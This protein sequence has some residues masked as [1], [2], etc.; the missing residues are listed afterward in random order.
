MVVGVDVGGK[1]KGFH[2]VALADGL[3]SAKLA[4]TS[5]SE[6]AHWCAVELPAA[7]IAVD[8]PCRWSA[9]AG[10]RAAERELRARHITCFVT[11]TRAAALSH[12][13]NYYEWM[14]RG[15]SLYQALEATHPVCEAWPSAR[16][17]FCFETFPHAI[18]WQMRGGGADARHKRVQRRRLLELNGIDV[19]ELTTMD[20]IDA[21]LCALIAHFA[22]TGQP[23]KAF[24][25]PISGLIIAPE[26]WPRE[27]R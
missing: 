22:F 17:R 18:T 21:A 26:T 15:E 9:D 25:E 8:A 20:F 16:K 3:Y 24:G 14:L 19:A 1:R 5:E 12:A 2:A 4:T 27:A 11:P 23:L 6:L 7:V 13:G 10:G